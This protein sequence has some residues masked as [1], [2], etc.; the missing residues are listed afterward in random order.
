MFTGLMW[1]TLTTNIAANIVAPA[2]AF[3]NMSPQRISFNL[4]AIITALIGL[5]IMPWKLVGFTKDV[6]NTILFLKRQ[7]L[8]FSYDSAHKSW[9]LLNMINT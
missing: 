7:W 6:A 3:V 1:A 4:G 8:P 2:N 5:V 9:H